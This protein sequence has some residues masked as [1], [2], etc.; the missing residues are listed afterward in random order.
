MHRFFIDKGSIVNNEV[1][2]NGDEAKHIKEVLRMKKNDSLVL[3]DGQKSEYDAQIKDFINKSIVCKI[4]KVYENTS[5]PPIN[6]VLFQSIPKSDKMDYIVQKCVEIGVNK[7]VPVVT[8]RTIVKLKNNKSVQEK[9]INRWKKIS[10][11]ASKQSGRGTVPVI[12]YPIM[13]DDIK[14]YLSDFDFEIKLLPYEKEGNNKL[15]SLLK[16]VNEKINI[17]VFIGPEG[18]FKE[19]EVKMLI[20][21]GFKIVSLGPRILRTETAGITVISIIQYEL[22]DVGT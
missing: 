5:E 14:E 17:A 1:I 3:F 9:K 4:N 18:G 13:M 6:I 21:C 12:D 22:G 2:I 11:E 20:D 15:K 7:I 19:E 10:L 16:E 8:E